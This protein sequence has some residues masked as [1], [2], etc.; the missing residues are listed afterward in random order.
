MAQPTNTFDSYDAVGI[1]EDISDVIYNVDPSTT[2]FFS[3]SKKV[4][5]NNSLHEWQTD[6]LRASANNAHIEGDDTTASAMTATIRLNNRTQ[7]FKDAVSIPDS[8]EGLSKAG[9]GKEMA[10]Q[11]LKVGKQIRLD[12]ERALFLNNAKVGGS[13]TVARELAGVPTWMTT[14]TSTGTSGSDATGDGSNARTN[15]TATAF[16]QTK[17]DTVLQSMWDAGGEPDTVYLS[18]FQM[19]KA[20]GF[21]GNNNQ[22][23]TIDASSGKVANVFDVYMT[24][25]GQVRFVPSREIAARDV[26]IAQSD[27]WAIATR[28]G[29]KQTKLGKTGDNERR[30]LVCELTLEA[31]NEASSGFIA[32]N[33][34][35]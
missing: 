10:Y 32:D 30:Q 15:G 4:K 2:P 12:I 24:P 34:I 20:L 26:F 31:R 7:I 1:R 18:S 23:G 8:D 29:M 35:V 3:S 6:S 21:T 27:M 17:M 19:K 22:R 9:R 25:W 14:S 13:A 5:A 28:R 33:T 16:S 11:I